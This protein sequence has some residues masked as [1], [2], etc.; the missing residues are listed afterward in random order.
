[1]KIIKNVDP[2]LIIILIFGLIPLLTWFK[3]GYLIAGSDWFPPINST[4]SIQRFFYQWNPFRGASLSLDPASIFPLQAFWS[5]FNSLHITLQ[6]TQ[7]VWFVFLFMAPGFT[8]YLLSKELFNSE[9]LKVFFSSFSYMFSFYVLHNFTALAT[10]SSYILTP[11]L[12]WSLLKGL[13]NKTWVNTTVFILFQVPFFAVAINPGRFLLMWIIIASFFTF[14]LCES[15]SR[16]ADLIYFFRLILFTILVNSWWLVSFFIPTIQNARSGI[17]SLS[18]EISYDSFAF[19]SS[20]SSIINL[21]RHLGVWS[22]GEGFKGSTYTPYAQTYETPWMI[23]ATYAV[24]LLSFLGI[25][26]L[27]KGRLVYFYLLALTSIFLG[28][29]VHSPFSEFSRIIFTYLPGFSFFKNP[30]ALFGFPYALSLSIIF[31]FSVAEIIKRLKYKVLMF[32]LAII[33]V[34]ASGFPLVTGEV[35]LKESGIFP[36]YKIKI[37]QYM[38]EAGSFLNREEGSDRILTLPQSDPSQTHFNWGYLG[39]DP[40]SSFVNKPV[41]AFYSSYYQ[42]VGLSGLLSGMEE[43]KNVNSPN[44]QYLTS[45]LGVRYIIQRNDIDWSYFGTKNFG[46]PQDVKTLLSAQ[47][48]IEGYKTFGAWDIYRLNDGFTRPKIYPISALT[49]VEGAPNSV[50]KI[51]SFNSPSL[52]DNFYFFPYPYADSEKGNINKYVKKASF[53]LENSPKIYIFGNRLAPNSTAFFDANA[54]SVMVPRTSVL[55]TS[56]LYF[57]VKLKE[58]WLISREKNEESRLDQYIWLSA[59]RASEV[60]ELGKNGQWDEVYKTVGKY[61]NTLERDILPLISTIK[62]KDYYFGLVSKIGAYLS[63]NEDLIEK[64]I[65]GVEDGRL[66]LMLKNVRNAHRLITNELGN[67][68]KLK[69]AENFSFTVPKDGSYSLFLESSRLPTETVKEMKYYLDTVALGNP[70]VNII[71]DKVLELKD[72]Q[73]DLGYHIVS[74]DFPESENTVSF[75]RFK[76]LIDGKSI[77]T[78]LADDAFLGQNQF[79]IQALNEQKDYVWDLGTVEAGSAYKLSFDYQNIFGN[80]LGIVLESVDAGGEKNTF[81]DKVLSPTREWANYSR[82]IEFKGK[83]EGLRLSINLDSRFDNKKKYTIADL[84]FRELPRLTVALYLDR[85]KLESQSAIPEISYRE[86]NPVRY[87]VS[88]SNA[89]N[90]YYLG[91]TENFDNG[92]VINDGVSNFKHFAVNGKRVNI[93]SY[94]IQMNDKITIDKTS[95][96]KVPFKDLSEKLKTCF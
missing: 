90:P 91:F 73:L 59:K 83:V 4:E 86:I 14:T 40:T 23:L 41:L 48:F 25:L 6:V 52:N 85:S 93:P 36:S 76:E 47:S 10:S 22:W 27:R 75:N 95:A 96:Q 12:I 84:E 49:Y 54:N 92:W 44:F 53:F 31:S 71:S 28:K 66:D 38:Y 30:E 64:T 77:N 79:V 57:L 20:K 70:S 51:Y 61:I 1:M 65:G 74:I 33:V 94:A 46:S 72:L 24:P 62:R 78:P 11:L 43:L 81:L 2:V 17:I 67:L 69:D 26:L 16:R 18:S 3:D 15:E 21:L 13:K 37:P 39:V 89:V 63:K 5:V 68:T 35:F 58:S 32:A 80:A 7:K 56:P 87:E 45:L 34:I 50:S 42:N 19:H 9:R 8:M 55:P 88:V 29:G 60:Y 82:V